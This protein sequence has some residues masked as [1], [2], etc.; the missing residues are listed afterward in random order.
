MTA[1]P[2]V[3]SSELPRWDMTVVYPSLES[4]EFVAGFEAAVA[5]VARLRDLFDAVGVAER[6]P[7]PLD[8]ALVADFERV[9]TEL[10][11]TLDEMQTLAA[12]CSAFVATDSRDTVAQARQ[13]ALQGHLVVLAQLGTRFTAWLGSL[14]V[15]DLI[16]H[17]PLAAD[18]AYALRRAKEQAAHLMSPAEEDLAAELSPS[19]AIAW[20]KLYS[21]VSS[22]I[23]VPITRGDTIVER[24]ITLVRNMAFSADREERRQGFVAELGAWAEHAVPIAAALNSIK[25][26]VNTLSRRRG[27]ATPLDQAID[28]ANIDRATLDAMFAAA[29]EAFPD[30][31]RY[32]HLKAQALAIPR[33]AFYDLFA[34]VGHSSRTWSFDDAAAFV[35]TQFGAFSQRLADLAG[36]AFREHWVDAEPRAGKRGGAFCMRLR[37]GESRVL[38][39]FDPSYEGMS[40]LAHELGHAY[41]NLNLADR[42]ALQ[43]NTPMTLAE[44]ASIFCET[45]VKEAALQDAPHEEQIQIIEAAIQNACQVTVD[46][47]SRFLFE[48]RVFEGRRD[49]ELGVDEL[50]DTMRQAQ[51]ETYGDGLDEG[52]LHPYMW[53]AKPHY[54]SGGLSFYN[55]PY[56]FGLLFGLGLFA[57]YQRDPEDFRRGYDDLLAATGLADAATLAQRF[58][59]DI[60]DVAFWRA[61]FDMIRLDIDRFAGLI[62]AA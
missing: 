30:F 36:R 24:P 4:P 31:R 49:R 18:H 15:E 20:G 60:H 46:I 37:R 26:Q 25:G 12:Y 47:M 22:Q 40:T 52:A 7:A 27:W 50:C 56:M 59:I 28:S 41:H 62:G 54:Y 2:D 29:R 48:Q 10:N 43:R 11:T 17:S 19:G 3:R 32:L 61:S 42:T 39:N 9:I 16:A 8:D 58:G 13:S 34:P 33:M 6:A 55:F 35:V 14:E 44:T 1:A 38:S 53:A 57:R 51:I 45:L 23:M 5:R 21:N